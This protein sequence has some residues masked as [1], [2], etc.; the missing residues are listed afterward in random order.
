MGEQ[1]SRFIIGVAGLIITMLLVGACWYIIDS[2]KDT[3]TSVGEQT[4]EMDPTI[5]QRPE[6]LAYGS[7][8]F[9]YLDPDRKP[10]KEEDK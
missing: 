1:L 4:L 6:G 8:E 5:R 3:Y 7:Y 2:H 10:E 9:D